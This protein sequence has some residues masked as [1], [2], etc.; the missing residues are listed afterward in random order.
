MSI[1]FYIL[2]YI[3]LYYIISYYIYTVERQ[4]EYEREGGHE[5]GAGVDSESGL[6]PRGEQVAR[7]RLYNIINCIIK[8]KYYMI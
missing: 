6:Q 5:H 3:I 7:L 2:Y 4:A 8:H 1:I